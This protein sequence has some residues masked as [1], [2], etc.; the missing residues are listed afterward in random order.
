MTGSR[1][2][3]GA[4]LE[5]I[6]YGLAEAAT[7][8]RTGQ[9]G[10]LI[11]L[12]HGQ[13]PNGGVDLIAATVAEQWGWAVEAH[14]ADWQRYGRGAGPRRNTVMVGLGADV[15]AAFPGA[16][17]TGTWDCVRKAARAGIPGRVWPLTARSCADGPGAPQPLTGL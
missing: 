3:T 1:Y 6:R 5:V 16:E 17:S 9:G 13:C 12:V 10:P 8:V 4:D 15:F 11:T 7:G 2:A 14:P